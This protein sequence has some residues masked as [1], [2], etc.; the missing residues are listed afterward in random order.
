MTRQ[1]AEA[2]ALQRFPQKM[3][4]RRVGES[5]GLVDVN[6]CS[7]RDYIIKLLSNQE[8]Q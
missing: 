2:I 1:E 6:A 4:F 5:Y 3:E 8:K 7:R